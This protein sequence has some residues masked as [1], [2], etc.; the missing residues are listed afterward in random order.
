MQQEEVFQKAV[1]ECKSVE[2]VQ[3]VLEATQIETERLAEIAR[4]AFRNRALH[5]ANGFAVIQA[6][7]EHDSHTARVQDEFEDLLLHVA[8][9]ESAPKEVTELL[10][11]GRQQAHP[12]AISTPSGGYRHSLPLHVACSYCSVDMVKLLLSRYPHG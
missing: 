11:A 10:I 2:E 12:D 1:T 9:E 7:I 3:S 4:V 6:L 8:C 5:D